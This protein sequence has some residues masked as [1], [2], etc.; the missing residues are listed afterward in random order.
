MMD[1]WRHLDPAIAGGV[2]GGLVGGV[3][4]LIGGF[5]GA[6]LVGW[7]DTR[8]E[9]RAAERE[10]RG[11]VLSVLYELNTIL[12]GTAVVLDQHLY[13]P[14]DTPDWAYRSVHT[15][16]F[17]RLPETVAQQVAFAYSQ[18]PILRF[19]LSDG[20]KGSSMNYEVISDVE[21]AL[22]E[23]HEAIRTYAAN[24]P[25]LTGIRSANT[26]RVAARRAAAEGFTKA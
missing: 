8:R 23:A 9:E 16:L 24:T 3:A 14:I 22:I 20:A 2:V 18:L 11:A 17:A 10:H 13:V 6:W 26:S 12:F 25:H 7:L 21:S 4:T 1:W 19:H 15:V 5:G